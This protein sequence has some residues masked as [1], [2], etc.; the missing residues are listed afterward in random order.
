MRNLHS[1]NH[2]IPECYYALRDM[3]TPETK[4][5]RNNLKHK[6]HKQSYTDTL[7][8]TYVCMTYRHNTTDAES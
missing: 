6:D 5:S 1:N 2:F 7:K 3:E 8:H 4:L